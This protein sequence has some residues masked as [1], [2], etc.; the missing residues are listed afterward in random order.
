MGSIDFGY[1]FLKVS[2]MLL[3]TLIFALQALNNLKPSPI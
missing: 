3:V 1:Q 2:A